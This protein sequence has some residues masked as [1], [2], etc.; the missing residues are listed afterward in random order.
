MSMM[1]PD[2]ALLANADVGGRFA[3]EFSPEPPLRSLDPARIWLTIVRRRK[4]F[5]LVAIPLFA[6]VVLFTILQKTQ[7]ATNVRLLAGAANSDSS[8]VQS[9]AGSTDLSILNAFIAARGSQT[10][11]T[12]IDLLLQPTIAT[13]VAQ[14]ININASVKDILKAVKALPVPD[15]AIISLTATWSDPKT[16][17]EIANSWADVFTDHERAL[18]GRQADSLLKST[19][20]QLPDADAKVSAA[21]NEL[22]AYE[23]LVNI[24]SLQEQTTNLVANQAA[25]QAKLQAAQVEG[26]QAEQSLQAVESLLASTPQ[27]I[28]G[29]ESVAPNP[30]RQQAEAEV[31]R[32]SGQLRQDEQR[33][34]DT[35]PGVIADKAALISAQ[36]ALK[37][38]PETT[39]GG[40]S[41]IPNPVYQGLQTQEGQLNTQ[42]ASAQAQ[43][44]A[45]T[46]Q[47]EQGKPD[48]ASLP[49]KSRRI[50]QLEQ[51]LKAAQDYEQGLL[52]KQRE[53]TIAKS[54]AISDVTVTQTADPLAA[55]ETPNRLLNIA[56]GLVVAIVLGLIA[57]FVAEFIDDRFRTGDDIRD[58]LGLPLL[59]TIPQFDALSVAKDEWIKPLSAESFH[60]L[61][62]SLRYS[63]NDPPRSITFTS[64]DRGDG[65][66][67]VVYNTA[68][69]M[70]LMGQRVLVIDG[71]LRRPTIHEKFGISNVRGL[72]DVLVGLATLED[73][74]R[75][76]EHPDVFV[77]TAGRPVP[78]PVGL[79][80]SER[81]D[82]VLRDAT[83][84]Y[85]QVLIDG[86]ALRPI[87]DS[88]MLGLKTD[89][90]VL[91]VS[92]PNSNGR[93]VSAALAK[94]RSVG[95]I[96][97]LG[98]VLNGTTPDKREYSPY[99]LG[100]GQSIS[101]PTAGPT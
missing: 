11:E 36:N 53:A 58:R 60:Q 101:L 80:Q 41:T 100:M 89:G 42:I 35:F 72:A 12:Y 63:S 69:S 15:T 29:N 51:T 18:I 65:K 94:L 66:S 98:I 49:E 27:T 19:S 28:I 96:N 38:M 22:S 99:Y 86:P 46:Q 8:P 2:P 75:P 50:A 91:V 87:V 10:P 71:D 92:S 68:L 20:E 54:T 32:L 30:A 85:Q 6:L 5:M 78:N 3:N 55:V 16:S 52:E 73:V 74:I 14:K 84:N 82:R 44:T 25:L 59:G 62:A 24:V 13:D 81:F 93:T 26:Q 64:P 23:K 95:S 37:S 70:G 31:A 57:V 97:L 79:L 34:T 76:T 9:S 21:Q 43:V 61:V 90:V 33:Y 83:A 17:A 77:L 45:L 56:L 47:I 88:L 1:R 4:L 7:Y 67:T 48:I 39:F 40:N